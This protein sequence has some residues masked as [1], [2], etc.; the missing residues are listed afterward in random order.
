MF[1]LPSLIAAVVLITPVLLAIAWHDLRRL[2]VPNR[3]VLAV[4]L[5]FLIV[6]FPGGLLGLEWGLPWE[7]FLKRLFYGVV[8]F[9]IGFGIHQIAGG[10]VGAGD[11]KLIAALVPFL[12]SGSVL[13]FLLIYALASFAG[14]ALFF[15]ARMALRGRTSGWAALDQ[16]LY[17]PAGVL[18]GIAMIIQLATELATRLGYIG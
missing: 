15:L 17:F 7:V 14:L 1:A 5:C 12:A 13:N 6:G 10:N 11:L 8:A 3:L 16:A 2:K 9:F 18:L 4:V